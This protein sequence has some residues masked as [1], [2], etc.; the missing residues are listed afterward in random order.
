MR[1]T[2]SEVPDSL[3]FFGHGFY[4]STNLGF[5]RI[6]HTVVQSL[7]LDVNKQLQNVAGSEK[8]RPK[9]GVGQ[10]LLLNTLFNHHRFKLD[11]EISIYNHSDFNLHTKISIYMLG[12]EL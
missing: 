8:F 11:G 9:S 5:S 6:N 7:D 2:N 4:W 1:K 12:M 10:M 3:D